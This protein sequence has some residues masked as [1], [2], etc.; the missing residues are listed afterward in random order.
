MNQNDFISLTLLPLMHV[1]SINVSSWR[2]RAG[3]WTIMKTK[4]SNFWIAFA[5]SFNNDGVELRKLL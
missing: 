4:T 5:S 3:K 2:P 1:Q